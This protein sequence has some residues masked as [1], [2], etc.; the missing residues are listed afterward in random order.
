MPA[1]FVLQPDDDPTEVARQ[2]LDRAEAPEHVHWFPRPDTPGGGVFVVHDER[3]AAEVV[4]ARQAAR[5]EQAARIEAAQAKAEERD[6]AADE[7]GLTPGELG[8]PAAGGTDPGSAAEMQANADATAEVQAGEGGEEGE[9]ADEEPVA[10]DPSTPEDES[11]AQSTTAA[12]RAARRNR[13]AE[14]GAQEEG[15]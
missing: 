3:V 6:Q 11:K 7:T 13:A 2:L 1:E 10:D 8:F 14:A 9:P 5:A 12:R 4:Q 15:K